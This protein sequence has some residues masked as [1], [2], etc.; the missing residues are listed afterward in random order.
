MYRTYS[1]TMPY[2][3]TG[4]NFFYALVKQHSKIHARPHPMWPQIGVRWAKFALSANMWP[5]LRTVAIRRFLFTIH[6]YTNIIHDVYINQQH[7][8]IDVSLPICLGHFKMAHYMRFVATHYECHKWCIYYLL[9]TLPMAY[10]PKTIEIG[11]VPST[12]FF[13]KLKGV[14]GS[15]ALDQ[16]V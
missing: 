4:G 12:L 7:Y 11:Q 14:Q 13:F 15:G 10:I 9:T 1:H 3:T 2:S 5:C 6:T 16:S 8:H